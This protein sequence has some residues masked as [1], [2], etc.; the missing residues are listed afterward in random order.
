MNIAR[1]AQCPGRRNIGMHTD[2]GLRDGRGPCASPT[3]KDCTREA[4][5]LGEM[6]G[7]QGDFPQSAAPAMASPAPIPPRHVLWL[8]DQNASRPSFPW[9][10]RTVPPQY[11]RGSA[12]PHRTDSISLS[13]HCLVKKGSSGL[14]GRRIVHQPLPGMVWIQLP[15]LTPAG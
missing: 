9:P 8:C 2:R 10:R 13:R 15:R 12:L 11:V 5:T 3:D 7:P 1:E 14:Y 4:L 6:A